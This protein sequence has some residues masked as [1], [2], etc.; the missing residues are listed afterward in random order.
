MKVTALV[1][2]T[3]QGPPHQTRR[4]RVVPGDGI[5]QHLPCA[6]IP[7][8][9]R[10]PLIRD[11]QSDQVLR[12]N[13]QQN[14]VVES[15]LDALG[16]VTEQSHRIVFQPATFGYRLFIRQLMDGQDL[17]VSRR[18]DLKVSGFVT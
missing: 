1:L 18:I 2:N 10:F 12:V 6:G 16:D 11:S 7:E 3:L 13:V 5:A 17:C 8:Q 9:T 14:Q 4:P 15:H